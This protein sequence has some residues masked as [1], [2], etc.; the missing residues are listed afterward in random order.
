M[1]NIS[2]H[3]LEPCCFLD[4]S[5]LVILQD[6]IFQHFSIIAFSVVDLKSCIKTVADK[7]WKYFDPYIMRKNN[8]FYNPTILCFVVSVAWQ[9]AFCIIT[10]SLNFFKDLRSILR[11]DGTKLAY[12]IDFLHTSWYTHHRYNLT[13]N[14]NKFNFFVGDY[15][16]LRADFL[17]CHIGLFNLEKIL[18]IHSK[19]H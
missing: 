15:K 1:E 19:V 5:V 12:F 10:K 4:S 13:I 9:L 6:V 3:P 11:F 17:I 7:W 14:L 8:I 2:K 18:K 16:R